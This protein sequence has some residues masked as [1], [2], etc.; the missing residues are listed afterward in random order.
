MLAMRELDAK[1]EGRQEGW[2]Q[3]ATVLKL[4]R[5]GKSLEEISVEVDLPLNE[6]KSILHEFD[7]D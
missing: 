7:E 6:V 1:L 2:Q 5:K 3:S 4:F